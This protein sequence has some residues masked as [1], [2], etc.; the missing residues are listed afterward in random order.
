MT[1]YSPARSLMNQPVSISAVQKRK[2]VAPLPK[3]DKLKTLTNKTVN[4]T[5]NRPSTASV[6]K[7][8]TIENDKTKAAQLYATLLKQKNELEK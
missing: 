3:K 4:S 8:L 6:S 5:S 2:A 1:T 7:N